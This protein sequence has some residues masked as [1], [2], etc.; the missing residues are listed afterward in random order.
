MD[1]TA[2]NPNISTYTDMKRELRNIYSSNVFSYKEEYFFTDLLKS[3]QIAT[4]TT[5]TKYSKYDFP[6]I[7]IIWE[8]STHYIYLFNN[9]TTTI[10][11]KSNSDKYLYHIDGSKNIY[12]SNGN[13]KS[14]DKYDTETL[15]TSA[16]VKTITNVIGE[17]TSY[18]DDIVTKTDNIAKVVGYVGQTATYILSTGGSY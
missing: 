8:N 13:K 15:T 16:G 7:G 17:V 10:Q 18:V 12:F 1:D 5:K 2:I 3:T 6:S 11:A 4:K 14:I 9:Q